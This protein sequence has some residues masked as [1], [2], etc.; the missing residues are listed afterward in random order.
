M[1]DFGAMLGA[2]GRGAATVGRLVWEAVNAPRLAD[3]SDAQ[4]EVSR[5]AGLIDEGVPEELRERAWGLVVDALRGVDHEIERMVQEE[6]TGDDQGD[7]GKEGY[8]GRPSGL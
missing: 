6:A 1:P 4:Y 2:I 3:E 7:M 8:A 5:L